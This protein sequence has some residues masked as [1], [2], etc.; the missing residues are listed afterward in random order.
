MQLKDIL[1]IKYNIILD[2][3]TKQVKIGGETN[4]MMFN[5]DGDLKQ[6]GSPQFLDIQGQNMIGVGALVPNPSAIA[7]GNVKGYGFTS[8]GTDELTYFF[9]NE[10]NTMLNENAEIHLHW[11]CSSIPEN[12]NVKWDIEILKANKDEAWT[13]SNYSVT[14]P[15]T[16]TNQQTHLISSF[17]NSFALG[18]MNIGACILIR[19]TRDNG[20]AS[21]LN[22][23]VQAIQLGFHRKVDTLG[24]TSMYV[25]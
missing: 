5:Q 22:Q 19:L 21:N 23:T 4:Y 18:S 17:T 1:R 7:G 11:N 3:D 8:N 14:I 12:A 24:S 16:A 25:K 15:L 2:E 20:V 10:H 9:E 6:I 13:T